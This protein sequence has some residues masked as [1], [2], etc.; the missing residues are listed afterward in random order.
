MSEKKLTDDLIHSLRTGASQESYEDEIKSQY[1]SMEGYLWG[2]SIAS[3]KLQL[4]SSDI[5]NSLSMLDRKVFTDDDRR[6]FYAEEL[7]SR[8]KT[9]CDLIEKLRDL[10]CQVNMSISYHEGAEA[11]ILNELSGEASVRVIKVEDVLTDD[12][13]NEDVVD[14][15]EE[16]E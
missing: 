14:D 4:V 5:K 12:N 15:D 1:T 13:D 10:G 11:M 16:E 7:V 2:K 8:Y 3:D 6:K 9:I